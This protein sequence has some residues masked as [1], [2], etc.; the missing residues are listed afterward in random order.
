MKKKVWGMIAAVVMVLLAAS[1]SVATLAE[2]YK[3]PDFSDRHYL[4]PIDFTP[5]AEVNQANYTSSVSYEDGTIQAS[6]QSGRYKDAE[7]QLHQA[8]TEYESLRETNDSLQV[9]ADH[10]AFLAML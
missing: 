6:I 9:L 4:L 1:L 3:V 8:C 2:G 10:L 5:G 7:E